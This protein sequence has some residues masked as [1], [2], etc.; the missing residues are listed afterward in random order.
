VG[1]RLE[2][3]RIIIYLSPMVCSACNRRIS[4]LSKLASSQRERNIESVLSNR[5]KTV[6]NS[7]ILPSS[8]TI[9]RS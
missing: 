1:G 6:S 3:V 4:V 5:F 7:A 9:I 2:S 8:I